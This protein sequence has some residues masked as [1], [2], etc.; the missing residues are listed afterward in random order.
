V[1]KGKKTHFEKGTDLPEEYGHIEDVE[2]ARCGTEKLIV[3][4]WY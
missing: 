2:C 3:Y 4:D 1:T